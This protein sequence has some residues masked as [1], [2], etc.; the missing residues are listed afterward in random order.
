M[1]VITLFPLRREYRLAPF[2]IKN[3]MKLI[4]ND[5]TT[6]AAIIRY[7]EEAEIRSAGPLWIIKKLC[8]LHYLN[9]K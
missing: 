2:D 6:F 3:A 8:L 1:A 5:L 9:V 7:C 4:N